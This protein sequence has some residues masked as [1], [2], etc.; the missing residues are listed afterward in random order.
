MLLSISVA[1]HQTKQKPYNIGQLQPINQL[2]D[3]GR[4]GFHSWLQDLS[5]EFNYIFVDVFVVSAVG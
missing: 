3:T 2:K 1:R 5:Y 4:L